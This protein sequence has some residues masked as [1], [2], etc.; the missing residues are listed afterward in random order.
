MNINAHA[1]DGIEVDSMEIGHPKRRGEVLR[2]LGDHD[3]EH[4]FV[5]W[6]DGHESYF[7]PGSTSHVIHHRSCSGAG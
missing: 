2:V 1:G 5:R 7:Y 4:Y 3:T 6:D